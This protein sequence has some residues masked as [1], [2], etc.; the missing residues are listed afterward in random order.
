MIRRIS[1]RFSVI[2]LLLGTLLTALAIVGTTLLVT[3]LDRIEQSNLLRV[4][5]SSKDIAA[6]LEIFLQEIESRV[7]IAADLFTTIPEDRI[8]E[9]LAS[10]RRNRLDAIYVI[11]ASGRLVAASI[12]GA[13]RTREEELV[14]IDL[15]TYP[16]FKSA[17]ADS[18]VIWSDKHISAVTGAV[19]L[20]LA[21]QTRY[22]SGVIIAEV[23]LE[24]VLQLSRLVRGPS[25]IDFWVV[26]RN[27]EIVADTADTAPD[28][29]NIRSLPIITTGFSGESQPS[30]LTM[31]GTRFAVAANYSRSLDWLIVSRMPTGLDDPGFQDTVTTIVTFVVGALLVGSLLAS[32]WARS[33]ARPLESLS[34]RAEAIAGGTYPEKWPSASIGEISSLYASLQTM[35]E[36]IGIRES[37]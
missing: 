6:R 27:G 35:A 1:L 33:I 19:T 28:Q 20:G 3:T 14:G 12:K 23:S 2:L 21:R 11:D 25:Q 8:G 5:E 9:V 29:V 37:A 18:G 4:K 31:G 22:G 34:R 7:E 32:F 24:T 16:L 26:D 15:S 13:S 30:T 17:L 10:E 36:A